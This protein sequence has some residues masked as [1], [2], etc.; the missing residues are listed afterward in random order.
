[1]KRHAAHL[2][3]GEAPSSARPLPR[4]AALAFL[5]PYSAIGRRE[6]HRGAPLQGAWHDAAEAD[7]VRGRA[8]ESIMRR[9]IHLTRE[10]KWPGVR[11]AAVLLSGIA[12]RPVES[13]EAFRRVG[14]S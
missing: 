9:L 10:G 2:L 12:S 11:S 7:D 8:V 3:S 13:Y 14:V 1:M 4:N 5:K 6:G